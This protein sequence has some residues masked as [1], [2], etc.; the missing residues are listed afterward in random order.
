MANPNGRENPSVLTSLDADGNAAGSYRGRPPNLILT[1]D[2]PSCLER[3]GSPLATEIQPFNKKGRSLAENET[4]V[5]MGDRVEAR[6]GAFGR[7]P[8]VVA[9]SKNG[10]GGSG[11]NSQQPTPS[12]RDK[13]LG[14]T[15]AQ[16]VRAPS[17]RRRNVPPKKDVGSGA[18]RVSRSGGSGSRFSVIADVQESA[19]A[20]EDFVHVNQPTTNHG[21]RSGGGVVLRE[22]EDSPL[23]EDQPKGATDERVEGGQLR[24]AAPVQMASQGR[25]V[26]AKSSL[27]AATN[28]AVHV[29]DSASL[30]SSRTM[31]GRVLL[32]S[33]RGTTSKMIMKKP[34]APPIPKNMAPKQRKKEG[35][36][37]LHPTLEAGLSNLMEDLEQ[38]TILEVSRLG[39]SPPQGVGDGDHVVWEHNSAFEQE[40]LDQIAAIQPPQGWLD[41]DT[42]GWRWT[43]SR[44]FTTA[45]AY[46]FIMDTDP[47][48]IDPIWNKIWTA[49]GLWRR[50]LQPAFLSDFLHM[51]FDEW[52]RNNIGHSIDTPLYGP[53]WEARFAVF[54]WLLWKDRCSAV[55]GSDYNPKVDILFRG[56]RLVDECIQGA[57]NKF[58]VSRHEQPPTPHWCLPIPGWV[59]EVIQILQRT[60][61]SLSSTGLVASILRLTEHNWELVIRHIPREG[62]AL[63][64]SLSKWGRIHS[65]ETVILDHPPSTLYALVNADKG[66]GL[67]DPQM[68]QDWL[69][70]ANAAC[71]NLR[72]DPGG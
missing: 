23:R 1:V 12:F 15:S 67:R 25:V 2:E 44:Q 58:Q 63:A 57:A 43:V 35:R 5:P 6:T 55:L 32:S 37:A 59:K 60:S 46:A 27:P 56:N 54:C 38:A 52:L 39:S 14:T 28:V 47:S 8:L 9:D 48:S 10:D 65:P 24:Q 53:R 50:V 61:P 45:S 3:P 36:T 71:F 21:V 41:S 42:P 34:G 7:D 68:V 22:R 17:R 69:R 11:E 49:R 51:P 33:I 4:D 19:A 40:V 26:V 18:G 30:S 29:M 66:S 16:W 64:D 72:T 20:D 70:D 31:K 62:N 13:L